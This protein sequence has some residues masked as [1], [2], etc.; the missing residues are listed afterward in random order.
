[1]RRRS[2]EQIKQLLT[3]QAG[4]GESI[5]GYCRRQNIK[6]AT[7]Y[8]WRVKYRERQQSLPAAGFT[9]LVTAT[10]TPQS[11]LTSTLHL[12]GGARLELTDW[13]LADLVQLSR[14]LMSN[15]LLPDHA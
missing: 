12:P 13:P 5:A 9:R 8:A 6:P 2:P 1:M 3:E 10:P 15:K 11:L 7:F 4:S 14:E